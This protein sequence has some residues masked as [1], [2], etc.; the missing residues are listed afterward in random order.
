[1]DPRVHMGPVFLISLPWIVSAH[2][3][4]TLDQET[5]EDE[6]RPPCATFQLPFIGHPRGKGSE[7]SEEEEQWVTVERK[8]QTG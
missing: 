8:K 3:H 5:D 2:T 1:M 7:K 4:V 6:Q